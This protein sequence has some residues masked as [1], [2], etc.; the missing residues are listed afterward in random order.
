MSEE[1]ELVFD[2]KKIALLIIGIMAVM[3]V[4]FIIISGELPS[5]LSEIKIPEIALP[6][7][8]LPVQSTQ[9]TT[10]EQIPQP[11]PPEQMKG[12]YQQYLGFGLSEDDI[13]DIQSMNCSLFSQGNATMSE[14]P[15][16]T[17]IFE[18]RKAE[19]D[20]WVKKIGGQET[21]GIHTNVESVTN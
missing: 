5:F 15:K 6:E 9:P 8:E 17:L 12:E 4:V 2:Y 3:L 16:F 11:E 7:I 10:Q 21:S 1:Y 20:L 13:I 18:Q 19:C 14:D